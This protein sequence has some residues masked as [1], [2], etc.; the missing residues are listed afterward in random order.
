MR[1][2]APERSWAPLTRCVAR[3]PSVR[4]SPGAAAATRS[5]P[6]IREPRSWAPPMRLDHGRL[7]R[8]GAALATACSLLGTCARR[9]SRR[10]S[11]TSST[12]FLAITGA[13]VIAIDP[14]DHRRAGLVAVLDRGQPWMAIG[15]R[16][17]GRL[18]VL[19]AIAAAL[20]ALARFGVP[21]LRPPVLRRLAIFYFASTLEDGGSPAA[22]PL[23]G[24]L[25]RISTPIAST[26]RCHPG[27]GPWEAAGLAAALLSLAAGRHRGGGPSCGS[28]VAG[29]E[30][31]PSFD[32]ASPL[33]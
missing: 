17:R 24:N 19:A 16:L 22:S 5:R 15:R 26:Q 29:R 31:H 14:H 13:R 11:L 6:A 8:R 9:A 12:R 32:G 7:G 1:A 20:V 2:N 3:S 28:L 23:G 18:Q 30:L 4:S 25:A 21:G 10:A 33:S 27:A